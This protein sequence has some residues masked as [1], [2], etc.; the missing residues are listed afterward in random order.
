MKGPKALIINY[1]EIKQIH[2]KE[3]IQANKQK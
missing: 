1:L 2:S 3:Y